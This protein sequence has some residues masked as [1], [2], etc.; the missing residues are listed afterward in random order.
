MKISFMIKDLHDACNK[1]DPRNP[2]CNLKCDHF[3]EI[4]TYAKGK[5][6]TFMLCKY[7]L[8][9]ICKERKTVDDKGRP[10][11]GGKA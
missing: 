1:Q 5:N 10:K 7:A 9:G 4:I 11:K 3:P 8:I 2:N 6:T